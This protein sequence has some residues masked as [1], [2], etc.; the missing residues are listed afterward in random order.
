M[1]TNSSP[2]AEK[3]HTKASRRRHPVQDVLLRPKTWKAA[4][5]V[6]EFSSKV[7]SVGKEIWEMWL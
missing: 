1:E 3:K 2:S 7:V 5:A 4:I 6:L